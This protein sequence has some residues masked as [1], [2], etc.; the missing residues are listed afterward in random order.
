MLKYWSCK[1]LH[2][3]D[4]VPRTPI[5]NGLVIT[6]IISNKYDLVE[7]FAPLNSLWLRK[8]IETAIAKDVNRLLTNPSTKMPE[9]AVTFLHWK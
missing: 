1:V 7:V 6:V 2:L 5:C 9:V 3:A 8:W 4:E